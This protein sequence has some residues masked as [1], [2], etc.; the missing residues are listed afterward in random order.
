MN[1]PQHGCGRP[2][3]DSHVRAPQP[4]AHV[5]RGDGKTDPERE[6]RLT[7]GPGELFRIGASDLILWMLSGGVNELG[8]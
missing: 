3:T 7:G 6:T 8:G 2:R 1:S 5:R 4:R